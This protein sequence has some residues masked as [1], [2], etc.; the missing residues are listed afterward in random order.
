MKIVEAL[1]AAGAAAF[2]STISFG[3]WLLWLQLPRPVPN[4]P[5][6]C[7]SHSFLPT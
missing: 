2:P 7:R 4:F 1:T 3:M 5:G 6:I